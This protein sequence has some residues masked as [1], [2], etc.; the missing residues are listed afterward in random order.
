MEKSFRLNEKFFDADAHK[1]LIASALRRR[2][3]P[4]TGHHV[5]QVAYA[6]RVDERDIYNWM[7]GN[8]APS[9]L[10]IANLGAF[11][12]E[13]FNFEVYG[14]RWHWMR[15]RHDHEIQRVL[16]EALKLVGGE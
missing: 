5:K 13:S 10:N 1:Q 12:G 9:A 2:F 15:R 3:A 4:G 6:L 11:F 8:N 7:N 14:D 16:T